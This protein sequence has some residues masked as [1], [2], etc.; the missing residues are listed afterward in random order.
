MTTDQF[1]SGIGEA[2]QKDD[3]KKRFK[4][5]SDEKLA[6]IFK[7]LGG[8]TYA[9]IESLI[10]VIGEIRIIQMG[11]MEVFGVFFE[12]ILPEEAQTIAQ[13]TD[14]AY[15]EIQELVTM[16][17]GECLTQHF[18]QK[19][20]L[21]RKGVATV[22]RNL[23]AVLKM[24]R[25]PPKGDKEKSEKKDFNDEPCGYFALN[26]LALERKREVEQVEAISSGT[27]PLAKK[28]FN[29]QELC[30][31]SLMENLDLEAFQEDGYKLTTEDFWPE[32]YDVVVRLVIV[33]REG[34]TITNEMYSPPNILTPLQVPLHNVNAL[35]TQTKEI[36][37]INAH[38]P[39]FGFP[40][41][42]IDSTN[43]EETH[44]SRPY[45]SMKDDGIWELGNRNQLKIKLK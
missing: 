25:G 31:M 20:G 18:S 2:W 26:N 38:K 6:N 28:D 32:V 34:R 35:R 37:H 24:S 9:Q 42:L 8:L 3:C 43:Y 22:E 7:K 1:F 16:M 4:N 33:D 13:G 39:S 19:L 14:G 10:I 30:R 45:C 12:Y 17:S 15:Y 44:P 40:K 27:V 29:E 41:C 36:K 5:V 11:P 21:L 23:A